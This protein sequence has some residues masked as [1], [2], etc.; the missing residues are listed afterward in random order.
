M[1]MHVIVVGE[2][3]WQH[4]HHRRSVR[5]RIDVNVVSLE[6]FHERFRHAVALRRSDGRAA[7]LK[8]DVLCKTSRFSSDVSGTVVTQP[9]R[10]AWQ[11]GNLAEPIAHRLD[12][13]I[14]HQLAADAASRRGIGDELSIT[15]VQAEGKGGQIWAGRLSVAAFRR[16]VR[17]RGGNR[18][19]RGQRFF[20]QASSMRSHQSK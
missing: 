17:Q 19:R 14:T 7:G 8:S 11:F 3:D 5:C 10:W 1:G 18:G 12:H 16:C 9:L 6:G 13:D 2:P 15:A 20:L 4:L